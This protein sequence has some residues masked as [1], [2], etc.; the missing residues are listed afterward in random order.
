MKQLD[1]KIFNLS[2]RVI[3]EEEKSSLTLV[4]NRKSRIIMKDGRRL[5]D[6]IRQ[7]KKTSNKT[8]LI[9]TTAPVCS[10]T[11][12]FLNSNGV[13]ITQENYKDKMLKK[14][15]NQRTLNIKKT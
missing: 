2:S 1:P 6:Q 9:F 13:E 10:K 5:L 14:D 8:V 12:S 7:I 3:I 4:V 11:K 15:E